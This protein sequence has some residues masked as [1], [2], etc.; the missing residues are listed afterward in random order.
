MRCKA[1]KNFILNYSLEEIREKG[2]M[3]ISTKKTNPIS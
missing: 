2:E 3:K 1:E